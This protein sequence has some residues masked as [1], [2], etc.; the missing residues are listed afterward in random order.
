MSRRKSKKE[1]RAC[2]PKESEDENK[3]EPAAVSIVAEGTSNVE[4]GNVHIRRGDDVV[5]KLA[6]LPSSK[7]FKSVEA[8]GEA[9]V[10]IGNLSI[11]ADAIKPK[12]LEDLVKEFL[13]KRNN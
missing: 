11:D 2:A 4:I 10:S 8:S 6:E 13:K 7:R 5:Q 9:R 1:K 3:S 12:Q